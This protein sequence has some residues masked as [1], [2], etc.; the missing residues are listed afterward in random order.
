MCHTQR[1]SG[2]PPGRK[3]GMSFWWTLLAL[4]RLAI[5]SLKFFLPLTYSLTVWVIPIGTPKI[6][7]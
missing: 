6:C 7:H 4:P 5:P 3:T 1:L 2:Q